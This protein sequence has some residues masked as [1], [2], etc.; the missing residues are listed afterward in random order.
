MNSVFLSRQDNRDN[1]RVTKIGGWSMAEHD[2][3]DGSIDTLQ[4]RNKSLFFLRHSQIVNSKR[5]S[6][7]RNMHSSPLRNG[8]ISAL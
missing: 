4:N 7:I 1:K 8:I 2:A 5:Y 3:L 6:V